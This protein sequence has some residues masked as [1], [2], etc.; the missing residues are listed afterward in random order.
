MVWRYLIVSVVAGGMIGDSVDFSMFKIITFP[1]EEFTLKLQMH[2][3]CVEV[4]K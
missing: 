4:F 1:G 2:F 3:E